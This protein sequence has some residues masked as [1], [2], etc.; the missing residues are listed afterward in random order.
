MVKPN[1]ELYLYYVKGKSLW[2][3]PRKGKKGRKKIVEPCFISKRLKGYLYYAKQDR[4]GHLKPSKT[5]IKR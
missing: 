1:Y 3:M 4:T 2:Q 5:K